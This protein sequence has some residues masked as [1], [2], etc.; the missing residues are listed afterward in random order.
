MEAC[1][2]KWS[3]GGSVKVE[4]RVQ[5]EKE[6]KSFKFWVVALAKDGM[7][8]EIGIGKTSTLAIKALVSRVREDEMIGGFDGDEWEFIEAVR[9]SD[10]YGYDSFP[11]VV[12]MTRISEAT[13]LYV[14]VV[15]ENGLPVYSAIGFTDEQARAAM[16]AELVDTGDF[17]DYPAND[18]E[19]FL[20]MLGETE[21]YG[22]E[23]F[24]Y[25]MV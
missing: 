13:T 12:P 10:A 15:A 11:F 9:E 8:Y 17:P 7:P 5:Q 19:G 20:E 1:E 16:V 14:A 25:E 23:V 4:H 3:P 24:E 6:L 22:F 2:M 18:I 21:E